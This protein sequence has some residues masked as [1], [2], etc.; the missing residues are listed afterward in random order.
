MT[1]AGAESR[2]ELPAQVGGHPDLPR[3]GRH[4]L[5]PVGP[6]DRGH[7]PLQDRVRRPRGPLHRSMG[8]RPRPVRTSGLRGGRPRTR[9][10]GAPAPRP[11]RRRERV[12]VR[13]ARSERRA[14]PHRPTAAEAADWERRTVHAPGRPCL[15]VAGLGGAPAGV[16]LAAALPALR[17]WIRGR[18]PWNGR[19]PSSEDPA[20][21]CRA[22]RSPPGSPPRRPR[23][24]SRPSPTT[25]PIEA[26]TCWRPMPSSRP[27]S[28]LRRADPAR[29]DS[30]RSRRSSR[31]ATG[32]RCRSAEAATDDDIRGG[33]G[34]ST[35]QR[36]NGAERAGLPIARYDTAGWTDDDGPV[37]GARPPARARRCTASTSMLESTGGRRGFRFGPRDGVRRRGGSCR[38]RSQACSCTWK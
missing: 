2:A 10:V 29:R 33:F 37:R 5:R 21:T 16:R 30:S 13:G 32:S 25:S 35:R 19:G 3:A 22:V 24:A 20:R 36:I 27:T 7:R 1:Q 9:L 17:R 34:K 23:T 15:P 18:W 26:W 31:R 8:P 4:E 14:R 6:R 12:G 28:W 11:G 38:P